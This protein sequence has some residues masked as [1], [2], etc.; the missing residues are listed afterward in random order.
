M[1]FIVHT[2]IVQI[3]LKKPGEGGFL[4]GGSMETLW[5]PTGAKVPW[6]LK[7]LSYHPQVCSG[8]Y[9]FA[10][11]AFFYSENAHKQGSG[12]FSHLVYFFASFPQNYLALPTKFKQMNE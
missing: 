8:R 3:S 2:Y 10:H 7:C 1:I 4:R 5:T 11:F 6:S 12:F 9:F